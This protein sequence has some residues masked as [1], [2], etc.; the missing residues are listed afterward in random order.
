MGRQPLRQDLAIREVKGKMESILFGIAVGSFICAGISGVIAGALYRTLGVHDAVNFLRNKKVAPTS[1]SVSRK[2]PTSNKG[3]AKAKVSKVTKPTEDVVKSEKD[4]T[5]DLPT[6]IINGS[7]GANDT[8]TLFKKSTPVSG[9][10]ETER[11]TSLLQEETEN[12]T[13]IL[14]EETE[15]P[16]SLLETEDDTERPTSLLAEEDTERPTSVLSTNEVVTSNVLETEL[17]STFRFKI[18]RSD[19][20]VHTK[21]RI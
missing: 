5:A 1:R 21:E 18:T 6:D 4:E 9:E 16:T 7:N 17:E 10:E 12:P 3:S 13:T 20:V 8:N 2:K 19:I 15:R 14:E 11:P